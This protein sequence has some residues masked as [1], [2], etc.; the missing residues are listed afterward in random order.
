MTSALIKGKNE[1]K[2]VHKGGKY[3]NIKAE[4]KV[5]DL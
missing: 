2:H 5:V 3:E 1:T 4:I